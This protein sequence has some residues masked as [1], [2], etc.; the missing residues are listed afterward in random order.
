MPEAELRPSDHRF[1]QVV[2]LTTEY[3]WVA[4]HHTLCGV[5]EALREHNPV[6]ARCSALAAQP[7]GCVWLLLDSLPQLSLISMR[8]MFPPNTTGLDSP[9]TGNLR[10]ACP[11][12]WDAFE[13]V[14]ARQ[15]TDLDGLVEAAA[16]GYT[17]PQLT[18]HEVVSRAA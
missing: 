14:M 12:V 4:I 7:V 10:R 1:F 13:G 18:M 15:G 9:G 8:V 17:G 16:P 3:A 5:E 2:H 11:A 6:L